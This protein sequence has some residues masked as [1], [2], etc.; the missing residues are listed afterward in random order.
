MSADLSTRERLDRPLVRV[1]QRHPG[2]Q[3]PEAQNI[4]EVRKLRALGLITNLI[5]INVNILYNAAHVNMN[6]LLNHVILGLNEIINE[7]DSS[8]E[9]Q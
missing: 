4:I 3:L 9:S 5:Y 8:G 1:F 7:L 2:T 6:I